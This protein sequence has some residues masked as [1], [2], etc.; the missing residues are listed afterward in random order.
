MICFYTIQ[1]YQK[2]METFDQNVQHITKWIIHTDEL[3][4]E[5]EKKKPQQ[6]EDI[7]KVANKILWEVVCKLHKLWQSCLK[8]EIPKTLI[9]KHSPLYFFPFWVASF[10]WS[11]IFFFPILLSPFLS[12][13]PPFIR[14]ND[15]VEFYNLDIC[16]SSYLT[17]VYSVSAHKGLKGFIFLSY[18]KIILIL[19]SVFLRVSWT[20]SYPSIY[21]TLNTNFLSTSA[22]YQS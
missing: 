7:L 22:K 3:L 1:E 18:F 21:P 16:P 11:F 2:H 6:K 13:F 20:I 17:F 8:Y 4:D 10:F 9:K 19:M 5:S 12:Y 15:I 14:S